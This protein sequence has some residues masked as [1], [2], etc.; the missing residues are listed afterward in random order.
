MGTVQGASVAAA[1]AIVVVFLCG[2]WCQCMVPVHGAQRT[3]AFSAARSCSAMAMRSSS[4]AMALLMFSSCARS[5]A[6]RSNANYCYND[7]RRAKG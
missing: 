3:S 1:T 5:S 6:C 7:E 4:L 2:G